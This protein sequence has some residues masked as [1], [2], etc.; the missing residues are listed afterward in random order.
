LTVRLLQS[1]IPSPLSCGSHMLRSTV[2]ISYSHRDRKYLDR[3]RVHLR[4]LERQGIVELWDDTR[5][6][7]GSKWRDEIESAIQ[8]CKVALLLVSADFLASPFIADNELPPLLAAA[9]SDGTHIIPVVISPCR[10]TKT[11]PLNQFQAVNNPERSLSLLPGAEREK[12]WVRVADAVEAVLA[13]RPPTEGWRVAMERKVI[14]SL[15]ELLNSP[16]RSFLVIGT[17]DY[18]VQFWR[19][20]ASIETEAVSN[21]FLP[22]RLKLDSE[23]I[24]RLLGTGLSQPTEETPNYHRI[25]NIVDE[26]ELAAALSRRAVLILSDVYQVTENTNVN[27]ALTLQ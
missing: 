3:L 21:E 7:A 19:N 27:F 13:N 17:G 18:Y 9:A 4:P 26:K 23:Q 12:V 8:R 1:P 10:F 5:I 11:I 16:E 22:E 6:V 2:F 20:P 14:E 24:S 25:D 15:N